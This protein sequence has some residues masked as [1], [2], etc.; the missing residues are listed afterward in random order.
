MELSIDTDATRSLG[1]QIISKAEEFNTLLQKI[2]SINEE[3]KSAWSGEDALKYTTRVGEQSVTTQKLCTT[4]TETGNSIVTA[5]NN[6]D[7][8]VDSNSSAII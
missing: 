8:V 1:N 3:L 6:V 4:I 5:A 2:N 7:S